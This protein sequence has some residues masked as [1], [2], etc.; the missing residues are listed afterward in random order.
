MRPHNVAARRQPVIV[1][2]LS[3]VLAALAAC[4][5]ESS[6]ATDDAAPAATLAAATPA[7]A[8]T[9]ANPTATAPLVTVYKSP[10]CGCCSAWVDH[11]R[12]NGFAVEVHD[13]EDLVP[14]KRANGV[15]PELESC[16]T[17]R[18]GDYV[19]EGHVPAD[20]IAKLLTE[21]PDVAGL[22]VPGMP[23]GSPGMEGP[24][25]EPYDVIAFRKDGGTS[26][27]AHR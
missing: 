11:L 24:T 26:V 7:G 18:V 13:T 21:H 22:A 12:E 19:I 4:A 2:G 20:L 9:A 3:V 16:H 15:R 27:Y 5:G 14:V 10:T 6:P 17:A 25:K 8:A 23:M 1:L